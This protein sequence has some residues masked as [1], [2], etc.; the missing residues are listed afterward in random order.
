MKRNL[1]DSKIAARDSPLK[2]PRIENSNQH[3]QVSLI[4]YY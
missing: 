4:Q 2:L 1:N 3:K